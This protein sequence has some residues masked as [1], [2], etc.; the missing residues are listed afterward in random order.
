MGFYYD[1]NWKGRSN[2]VRPEGLFLDFQVFYLL[3]LLTSPL[4]SSQRHNESSNH[5][6]FIGFP[7]PFHLFFPEDFVGFVVYAP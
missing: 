7:P 5:M 3:P 1:L 6:F 4:L 2:F